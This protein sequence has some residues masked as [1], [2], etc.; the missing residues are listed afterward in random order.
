LKPHERHRESGPKEIRVALVTV[1]TSRYEA[2]KV[3]KHWTDESRDVAKDEMSRLGYE[4]TRAELISDEEPMIKSEAKKFL[5]GS[6]DVL[7][8]MGGTGISG[9]D[10][11]IE[12]VRPIFDKEIEGFGELLRTVSYRKI[13]PAAFLSR[14]SAGVANGKLIL[15]LPGSPGAARD[16]LRAFGREIP[17][18]LFVARS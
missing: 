10:V 14:A 7:V 9:R 13:G 3:G 6:E 18:A 1:S 17:H 2:K 16:A 15:C 4:V 5:A 12:T 11:T 8:M